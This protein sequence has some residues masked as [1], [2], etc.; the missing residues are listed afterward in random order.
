MLVRL[1]KLYLNLRYS[2]TNFTDWGDY[3]WIWLFAHIWLYVCTQTQIHYPHKFIE[4]K[5][6]TLAKIRTI[7][8]WLCEMYF[9]FV[10][11]KFI[12]WVNLVQL[13]ATTL[14]C[15]T[16]SQTINRSVNLA[17]FSDQTLYNNSVL[18]PHFLYL[19][20]LPSI[21]LSITALPNISK[22]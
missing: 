14:Q 11:N 8:L 9:V 2:K 17:H 16:T 19:S 21:Y 12:N 4:N 7:W 13:N 10:F 15:W 5:D 1:H 22:T 3:L 6:K 20:V 18:I